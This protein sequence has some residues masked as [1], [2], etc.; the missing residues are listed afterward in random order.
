M[1]VCLVAHKFY[2]INT[3]MRQFA[4]A[5]TGP[6]DTVD[7]IAVRR[8]NSQP[9]EKIDG[10]NVYRIQ[11][12]VDD[13]RSPVDHLLHMVSFLFRAAFVVAWKHLRDPYDIIHVQSIPDF[14]VFAALIPKLCG[15]PVVLDMRDL[16][17][18]L[19]ASKFK[20]GE[21]HAVV[22][23]LKWTEKLSALLADHVIVANPLWFKRVI[24]RSV[25][26]S[27]C[28]MFWSYPD[29]RMF[30]PRG[31]VRQD[32]K[33]VL[34]YP[35]TLHRHQ[36]VD[37]AIKSLP[38]ILRQIPEAELHIQGY[39][40]GKTELEVLSKEL[41][42]AGKVV[43]DG[44]VSTAEMAEKMAQCD[45]GL[46][47]KRAS[48]LFGNEAASTKIT[49]FMATGVPVV[50]SRTSIETH[51]YDDSMLRFF[52][53]EDEDALA[54]A[55]ISLYR[56]PGLRQSLTTNSAKYME[57]NNWG[58]KMPDYVRLMRSL[59]RKQS[60]T[61]SLSAKTAALGEKSVN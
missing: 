20:T 42:L 34:L 2:E 14:L 31:R 29:R 50:A 37:I 40:P 15:T 54:D 9:Y 47:P 32:G 59:V 24:A 56:D 33:F 10:V 30:Y 13:E 26:A 19:Y 6:G 12:R 21:N 4:S 16:S 41:N 53:S 43:F 44:V 22:R 17:P 49:E 7:V 25:D 23:L 45:V 1:R 38:K 28:S 46:V 48:N 8:A 52:R 5:F 55:I 35:G 11:Q 18:E 58:A 51:M 3:H 36:G 57:S 60:A 61:G 27:K 39:G